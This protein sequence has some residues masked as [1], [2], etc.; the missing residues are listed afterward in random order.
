VD[1]IMS[2]TKSEVAES[3]ARALAAALPGYAELE[4]GTAPWMVTK[5]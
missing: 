2:E 3:E 4:L 5:R 1:G